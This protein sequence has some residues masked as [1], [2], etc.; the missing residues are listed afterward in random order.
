MKLL[1]P[2]FEHKDVRRNLTQLFTAPIQ[3]VNFYQARKNSVLGDHFHKET[4]EYFFITKGTIMYN[5]E[6]ILNKGSLFV[7]HPEE[8]HKIECLTDVSLMSFLT[9]P[10]SAESPDQ[11]K[12]S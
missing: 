1:M 4:I 2:E 12:K 8:N 5:Q 3:Q 7:V 6:S 10:Y 11:W 9:K